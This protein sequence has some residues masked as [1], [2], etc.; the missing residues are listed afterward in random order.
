MISKIKAGKAKK[1]CLATTEVR[2]ELQS[3]LN[4]ILMLNPVD[5]DEASRNLKIA[6]RGIDGHMKLS[7]LPPSITYKKQEVPS[8]K[9]I[10]N[11]RPKID[12]DEL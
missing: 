2:G 6:S 5:A 1:C 4:Q 9:H 10:V 7:I 3:H 12:Y 11:Q 8:F